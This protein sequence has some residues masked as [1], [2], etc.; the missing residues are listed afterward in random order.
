LVW[1]TL[2]QLRRL[3]L[4]A[5]SQLWPGA[6]SIVAALASAGFMAALCLKWSIGAAAEG[7]DVFD[8]TGWWFESLAGALAAGLLLWSAVRGWAFREAAIDRLVG[9]LLSGALC[10]ATLIGEARVLQY[11]HEYGLPRTDRVWL[12][13]PF[14]VLFGGLAIFLLRSAR[15][16]TREGSSVQLASGA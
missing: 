10:L 1:W 3:S 6:A 9:G 2:V 5:G 12:G 8:Y 11:D 15:G 16:E 7:A 4:A 14:A 13:V